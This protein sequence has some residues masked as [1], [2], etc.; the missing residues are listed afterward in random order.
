MFAGL[1]TVPFG[2]IAARNPYNPYNP[3]RL[4]HHQVKQASPQ[5]MIFS[6]TQNL[7]ILIPRTG[8]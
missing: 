2:F 1:E 6:T 7:G 5:L 4:D 8:I 3:D